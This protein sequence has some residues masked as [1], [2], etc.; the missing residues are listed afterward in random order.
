MKSE[1]DTLIIIP[2]YNEAKNLAVL[3]PK[4]KARHP[5]RKILVIDDGSSDTTR[6]IAKNHEVTVL[7]HPFNLGYGVAVQTGYKYALERHYD[8]LVQMDADGQH[9]L[10]DT[11]LLL[12]PVKQNL[13]DL[14]LGSRF[15]HS[16]SY[17]PPLARKIGIKFFQWVTQAITGQMLTD[18]TSGFQAMNKRVFQI[19]A[20]R[21]FPHDYPDA[22][23]LV[24][25]HYYGIKI[26]EMPVRMY[27]CSG[28]SMHRG[29]WRP[30]FYMAK[31]CLSL[32]VT[33][34]LKGHFGRRKK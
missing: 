34:S 25:L 3:L 11:D 30:L 31:M 12:E 15:L 7:S 21:H 32:L 5:E 23:V 20:D 16:G 1:A 26:R 8:F 18:P 24:M 19:F 9:E 2:A 4:L 13:C 28:V 10:E 29:L 14:A 22:D 27:S 17:Q 6:E 33:Y